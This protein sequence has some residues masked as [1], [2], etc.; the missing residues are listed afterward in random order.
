MKAFLIL[1]KVLLI[2]RLKGMFD[3]K[4]FK[5]MLAAY[6]V[7]AVFGTGMLI[8]LTTGGAALGFI[9]ADI[10][11]EMLLLYYVICSMLTVIFGLV[12]MMSY[13][14]HNND[15]EFLASLPVP[16]NTVFFAKLFTVYLY[17]FVTGFFLMFFPMLAMGITAGA[18]AVY[19]IGLLF[20]VIL[21]PALPLLLTSILSVPLMYVTS[22]FKNKGVLSTIVFILVFGVIM[23]VYFTGIASFQRLGSAG[24]FNFESVPAV[25]IEASES[26]K[27]IFYPL[28][29]LA[30]FAGGMYFVGLD[31]AVSA[32]LYLVIALASF[33]ALGAITML[34]SSFGYR[35]GV[36]G[37]FEN[38]KSAPKRAGGYKVSAPRLALMK[39]EWTQIIK[40]PSVGFQCLF[41]VVI[42]PIMLF[43][44]RS[45]LS[46]GADESGEEILFDLSKIM[47]VMFMCIFCGSLNVAAMTPISREGANFYQTKLFP[48]S[49]TE[50]IRAKQFV[51]LIIAYASLA[52]GMAVLI[53]LYSLRPFEAVMLFI[54]ETLFIYCFSCFAMR[55]DIAG[56]KL[57]WTAPVEAIKRNA[58]VTT[59][60]LLSMLV[61][62]GFG[63]YFIAGLIAFVFV[64]FGIWGDLITWLPPV[65]A[66]GIMLPVSH[67][68]LYKNLEIKYEE[69]EF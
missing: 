22:F 6:I 68:A 25:F 61:T 28:Y 58:K 59:F 37:Q 47:G 18:G 26:L 33:F 45:L 17:E 5:S 65:I 2:S 3:S 62:S 8:A 13:M 46:F 11:A 55:N 49:Y 15:G 9:G 63:L 41:G 12:P 44:Y 67:K 51:N 43:A 39:R 29:A 66:A 42:M 24:E 4:R 35:R 50:Q 64:P 60:Q 69:I 32:V 57:N 34:I 10:L 36:L 16:E 14:Y 48:V 38:K 19:Y 21:V 30:A 27:K 53:T 56:P 23:L 1:V 52:A 31:P 20:A 40:N 54:F 7:L